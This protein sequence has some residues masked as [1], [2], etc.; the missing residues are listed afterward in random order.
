MKHGMKN[1]FRSLPLKQKLRRLFMLT[2]FIFIVCML[3]LF[4]FLFQ[5]QSVETEE[6]AM[7]RG[8]ITAGNTLQSKVE[9]VNA[10][11]FLLLMDSDIQGYL[12][13]DL[14]APGAGEAELK[15]LERQALSS[16]RDLMVPYE[17]VCSVYLVREDLRYACLQQDVRSFDVSAFGKDP[18]KA[19]LDE[20]QGKYVIRK[21]G[22][23]VFV[24]PNQSILSMMRVYNDTVTQRKIGYLSAN[25]YVSELSEALV[26]EDFSKREYE[27]FDF[28][29]EVIHATGNLS[30]AR[31]EKYREEARRRGVSTFV[32]DGLFRRD[33][34][35]EYEVEDTDITI[36]CID[37][38]LLWE[39]ISY[40]V[41]MIPLAAVALMLMILLLLDA[42][43]RRY[44]T[45]PI[46]QLSDSMQSVKSGWLSRAS[47]DTYDDEIGLLKDSYNDMIVEMNRLIRELL[48]KEETVHKTEIN[49]LQQQIKPHF[50]Y[51]TIEMIASLAVDEETDR[52]QIY[53]ALETLGSF[54]RQ[55]L[56]NGS[57]E[58]P[59]S[60]E[61]E[62]AKKYLKLQKLR[63][64]EIFED[65]YEIDPECL[66]YHLPKLTIQPIIENSLYHGIR[67]KG[68]FGTIRIR[69]FRDEDRV[70]V[71]LYDNGVGM[72]GS[73]VANIMKDDAEHFG[74]RR[75]IERFCYFEHRE[76]CYRIESK[77]GEFT[78]ITLIL[79]DQS[80]S[81]KPAE[82]QDG[83]TE[84]P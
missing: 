66:S 3:L 48:E 82:P 30:T 58:V 47:I 61:I 57:N 78:R 21:D 43:I 63:Y 45:R 33:I 14:S 8:L 44:V 38:Y 60:T 70:C 19:S 34:Y 62:I 2:S 51:N 22:D 6:K 81:E 36:A 12:K 42:L 53:D 15:Q 28:H 39:N 69:V 18:L 52:E 37:H 5:K 13:Y 84:E 35:S 67:P 40:T 16:M 64:G 74:L 1:P 49:V 11:T 32:T 46:R 31:F 27:F 23:G 7:R 75:T 41:I 17:E 50:L 77:E 29:G 59:L 10:F 54:Y 80:A 24:V 79:R 68:E 65:V 55:F 72:R 56:S 73:L 9:K 83:E 4:I 26:E 71:E 25:F 76:D 20:Q